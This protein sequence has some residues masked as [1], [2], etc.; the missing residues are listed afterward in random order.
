MAKNEKIQLSSQVDDIVSMWDGGECDNHKEVILDCRAVLAKMP[1][2]PEVGPLRRQVERVMR[3]ATSELL[4]LA[5]EDED[6]AK[7]ARSLEE[8][9]EEAPKRRSKRSRAR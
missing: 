8:D 4:E 9:E 2:D 6:A 5:E 1:T 3:E 7:D